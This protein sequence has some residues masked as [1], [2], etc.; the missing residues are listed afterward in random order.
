MRASAIKPPASH[1][2]RD[3]EYNEFEVAVWLCPAEIVGSTLAKIGNSVQERHPSRVSCTRLWNEIPSLGITELHKGKYI[4][5]LMQDLYVCNE[6]ITLL[7]NFLCP[8]L[9]H[10]VVSLLKCI[11]KA[12]LNRW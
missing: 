8:A 11:Q 9:V 5:S 3:E 10:L 4:T 12:L 7:R 1:I 6:G 2:R